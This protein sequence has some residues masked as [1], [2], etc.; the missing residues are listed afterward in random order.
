MNALLV[1]RFGR[2]IRNVILFGS[3]VNG[4][5]HQNSDYDILVVLNRDY[6]WKYRREIISAVYDLELKYNIFID[7]KLISTNELNHTLKGLHPI[8]SEAIERGIHA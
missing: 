2:D 7:L 5:P 1:T 4:H 3:Q 6:D 8:Y